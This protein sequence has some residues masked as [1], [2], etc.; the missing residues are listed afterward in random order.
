MEAYFDKYDIGDRV[1][2]VRDINVS[3][4]RKFLV[5]AGDTGVVTDIG[6]YSKEGRDS[7]II[8]VDFG[9][10]VMLGSTSKR[11]GFDITYLEPVPDE[12]ADDL[13]KLPSNFEEIIEEYLMKG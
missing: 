8:Y 1:R 11:M 2:L 7:K 5:G 6:S 9:R 3:G 12:E 10:E 4:V 13:I